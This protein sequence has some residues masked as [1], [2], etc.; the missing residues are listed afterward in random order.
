MRRSLG[1]LMGAAFP[2]LFAV[3]MGLAVAVSIYQDGICL[4]SLFMLGVWL[5]AT[6]ILWSIPFILQRF[7][8]ARQVHLD[9]R[10][11]IIFKDSLL[12]AHTVCWFYFLAACLI[13]WWVVG[14]TGMVSVNVLPLLFVGWVVVFQFA[15][16]LGGSILDRRG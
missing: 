10:G 5:L 13:A 14:P 9:E 1:D 15:L 16:V 12:A 8:K 4:K 6:A 7:S 11:L 3:I 2:L